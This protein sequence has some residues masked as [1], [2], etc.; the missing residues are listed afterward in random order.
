MASHWP[1]PVGWRPWM[2]PSHSMVPTSSF[3]N[4]PDVGWSPTPGSMVTLSTWAVQRVGP[5][6]RPTRPSG[7]P[8]RPAATDV[9]ISVLV[10]R[11][12]VLPS[13]SNGSAPAS[14]LHVAAPDPSGPWATTTPRPGGSIGETSHPPVAARAFAATRLRHLAD[15]RELRV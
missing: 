8:S 3:W 14:T 15:V 11:M 1:G 13:G 5:A 4:V 9:T 7:A 6:A 2:G 10:V 12:L